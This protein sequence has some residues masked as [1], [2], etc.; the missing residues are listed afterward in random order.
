MFVGCV[1]A[2]KTPFEAEFVKYRRTVPAEAES[3]S[4]T[5]CWRSEGHG[6]L[7]AFIDEHGLASE[8]SQVGRDWT[9][10]LL[11]YESSAPSP[12][13]F[14]VLKVLGEE[15]LD[16]KRLFEIE[17]VMMTSRRT[18]ALLQKHKQGVVSKKQVA[19]KNRSGKGGGKGRAVRQQQPFF[20]P[21]GKEMSEQSE[22]DVEEMGELM[23]A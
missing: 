5:M 16:I 12:A 17:K 22:G 10:H 21:E 9:Y 1:S 7:P 14:A 3:F 2:R 11:Q 23:T 4:L 19:S 15:Q 6:T 18:M 8:M 20:L 13:G